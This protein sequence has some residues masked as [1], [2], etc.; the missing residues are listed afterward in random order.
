MVEVAALQLMGCRSDPQQCQVIIIVFLISSLV[1][2]PITSQALLT[3]C[4]ASG[5]IRAHTTPKARRYQDGT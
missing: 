2:T 1:P 5:A 4:G 3:L